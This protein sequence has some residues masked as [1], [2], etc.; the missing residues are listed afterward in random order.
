MEFLGVYA[1]DMTLPHKLAGLEST[2]FNRLPTGD[3]AKWRLLIFLL[4][5]HK[6][7]TPVLKGKILTG[8]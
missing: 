2:C 8:A 5:N 4:V 3:R 1:D 6:F 7:A